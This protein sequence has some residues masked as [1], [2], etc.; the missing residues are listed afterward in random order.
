MVNNAYRI[1]VETVLNPLIVSDPAGVIVTALESE[2][3][4]INV[5]RLPVMYD[6][7]GKVIVTAPE[8]VLM[9]NPCQSAEA[10]PIMDDP[11]DAVIALNVI[12]LSLLAFV[13]ALPLVRLLPFF[14]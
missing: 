10:S 12:I 7:V 1:A 9:L 5:S 8:V 13:L 4:L 3:V 6:A 2:D 11:D 14:H